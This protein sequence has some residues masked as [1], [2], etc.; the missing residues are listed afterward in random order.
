MRNGR[1]S[2]SRK[3]RF[4]CYAL[5]I[6]FRERFV[7]RFEPRI[8]RDGERVGV[9]G[10]R[11]QDGFSA[12]R[13]DGFVEAMRDALAAYLRFAGMNRF[14]WPPHLSRERRLPSPRH[15]RSRGDIRS[16]MT[17]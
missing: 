6:L 11:R 8:D 10:L 13:A 5:P 15:I 7:G 9:L 16:R 4:D 14:D 17:T 3:H 12:Q 2:E 1:A